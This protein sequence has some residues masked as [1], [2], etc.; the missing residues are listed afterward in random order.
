MYRDS[1]NTHIGTCYRNTKACH[2]K[3][4]PMLT[5]IYGHIG[6]FAAICSVN[7]LWHSK[8]LN[9]DSGRGLNIRFEEL[10]GVECHS[11]LMD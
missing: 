8:L 5:K 7:S 6:L 11:R 4:F 10:I 2:F 1:T 9:L 3:S